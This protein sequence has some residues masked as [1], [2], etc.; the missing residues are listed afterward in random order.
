MSEDRLEDRERRS[1]H[2]TLIRMGAQID[3]VSAQ[4]DELTKK[5]DAL[6]DRTAD[7]ATTEYVDGRISKVQRQLDSYIKDTDTRIDVLDRT[8][9]PWRRLLQSKKLFSTAII[10]L[11][12]FAGFTLYGVVDYTFGIARV[13]RDQTTVDDKIDQ[14]LDE[15]IALVKKGGAPDANTTGK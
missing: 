14:R 15:L 9:S 13:D 6:V 10:I 8:S 3:T 2:D 12:L 4:L 1:D 11:S 7:F 5:M